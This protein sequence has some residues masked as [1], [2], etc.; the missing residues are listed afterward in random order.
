MIERIFPSQFDNNYRG[1]KAAFWLLIPLLLLKIAISLVALFAEDGGAQSAD[2]IPL[3]SFVNGAAE[4]VVSLFALWGLTQFMLCS[5]YLLALLRYRALI[6]L[7][8]I[9]LLVELLAK[10]GIFWVKPIETTGTTSAISLSHVLIVLSIVGLA[11]SLTGRN[12]DQT[13][14]QD[15]PEKVH[16]DRSEISELKNYYQEFHHKCVGWYITV[17]GFF[18]AGAIAAPSASGPE[19]QAIAWVIIFFSSILSLFFFLCIFHFSKRIEQ[20]EIFIG[21]GDNAPTDWYDQA[22]DV[23]IAVHGKGSLFFLGIIFALLAVV[24]VLMWLKYLA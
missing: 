3:D 8:Y 12:Y 17:M 20:L 2:G 16:R 10:K 9:M 13:G 11:L 1:H 22:K 15:Q 24:L 21:Q 18:I 5:V 23:S 4:V 6:P 7:V 14:E 19:G